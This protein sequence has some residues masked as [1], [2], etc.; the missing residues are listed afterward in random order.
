L[1]KNEVITG[2]KNFSVMGL[3]LKASMTMWLCS[4]Q[5]GQTRK[6]LL[7]RPISLFNVIYKNISKCLVNRL[8]TFLDELILETQSAFIPG[9]LITDNVVI[10]FKSFHKIQRSKNSRDTHCTYKLD[11]SKAY[12]RVDWGGLVEKTLEKLGFCDRWIHWVMSCIRSVRFVVRI[13]GHTHEVFSPTRGSDKG[14]AKPLLVSLCGLGAL[15]HP[16]ERN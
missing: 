16:Q 4:S 7:I 14:S 5:K 12:D 11:L 6:T 13:N 3:C 1:M 15:L 9:R 8:R 2:I 10:A